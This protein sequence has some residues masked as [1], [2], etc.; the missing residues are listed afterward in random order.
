MRLWCWGG[1]SCRPSGHTP[2][3]GA[4]GLVGWPRARSTAGRSSRLP[5]ASRARGQPLLLAG[6][7]MMQQRRP[8]RCV[9][10]R[11]HRQ[12]GGYPRTGGWRTRKHWRATR[13]RA[14]VVS[15]RGWRP[16]G[17]RRV[18]VAVG[19]GGESTAPMPWSACR[20]QS[21]AGSCSA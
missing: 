12:G 14:G 8:L 17:A 4:G 21:H 18:V 11:G 16:G 6:G 13:A 3:S 19:R 15:R 5:R 10:V 20:V 2:S 7:G 9:P 1:V